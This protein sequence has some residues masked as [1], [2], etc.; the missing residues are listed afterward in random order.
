V[1]DAAGDLVYLDP[2]FKLE[3]R[4]QRSQLAVIDLAAQTHEGHASD[5]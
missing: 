2:P 5:I 1:P 3:P 4:L